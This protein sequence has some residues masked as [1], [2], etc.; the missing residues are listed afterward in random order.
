MKKCQ[1]CGQIIKSPKPILFIGQKLWACLGFENNKIKHYEVA[2]G[3]NKKSIRIKCFD[4]D[5]TIWFSTGFTYKDLNSRL[6]FT[7]QEAIK[8]PLFN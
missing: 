5:G 1:S 3:T 7:E 2:E 6:F 8:N 4:D